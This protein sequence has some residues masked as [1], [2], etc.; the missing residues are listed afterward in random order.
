MQELIVSPSKM[1]LGSKMQ[2]GNK[3]S[4]NSYMFRVVMF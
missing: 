2:R 1:H 4:F 3:I